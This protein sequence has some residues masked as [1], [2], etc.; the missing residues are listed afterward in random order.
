MLIPTLYEFFPW[1]FFVRFCQLVYFSV[2]WSLS[3]LQWLLCGSPD[4]GD[5]KRQRYC[6]SLCRNG[7]WSIPSLISG[8]VPR[9]VLWCRNGWTAC[10][11]ICC[12]FITWRAKALLHNSFNLSPEGLWSGS[13]SLSL[14]KRF[15]YSIQSRV[16]Q[17]KVTFNSSAVCL[18]TLSLIY[19]IYM[20][21]PTLNG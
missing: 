5:R 14:S 6:S 3:N 4:Y 7:S 9:Q 15:W 11:Y 20:N 17:V 13:L 19:M 12:W 16:W 18:P 10:S 21:N 8:E 1:L 2:Y